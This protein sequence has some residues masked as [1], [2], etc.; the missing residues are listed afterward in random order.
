MKKLL[1]TLLLSLF[2]TLAVY[3][4]EEA[5]NVAKPTISF[6]ESKYDFGEIKQG[7][8][9]THVFKFENTG[10][11]PLILSNVSVT[12]GCTAPSWPK[13]PIAPG[14][15]ADLHIK[16]NSRGK[17]GKQNKVITIHSNASNNVERVAITGTVVKPSSGN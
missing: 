8:V 6:Q 13:N 7:D 14:E 16:F 5:K 2:C 10:E 3:A 1:S 11:A 4:Q 12:C 9:V 15:T 17:M